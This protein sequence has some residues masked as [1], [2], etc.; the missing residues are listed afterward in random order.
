AAVAFGRRAHNREPESGTG[1]SV[2]PAPEAL[3]RARGLVGLEPPSLVA[4]GEPRDSVLSH[5]A[6][7]DAAAFRTV[8]ERVLDEVV[9]RPL[10]RRTVSA[11]SHRLGRFGDDGVASLGCGADELVEA[12]LLQRRLAGVL[13]REDE[14]VVDQP[15]ETR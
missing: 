15:R 3:E 14:Q 2:L 1:L 11:H 8:V 12:H 10:E 9:E 13:S 5:G 4:D 6:D 7:R